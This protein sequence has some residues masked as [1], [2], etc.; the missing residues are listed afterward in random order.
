MTVCLGLL[1]AFV[2]ILGDY[3]TAARSVIF[4]DVPTSANLK[5]GAP[6]KVAGVPAGRVAVV[7]YR[8]GVYDESL[9]RR[10]FVRIHLEVDDDK[11]PTI[12]EDAMLYITTQGVLGEKY[13]EI[14]P[15][16]VKATP[17]QA[18]AI[19]TGEP[20]MRLEV[21]AHNANKLLSSL[22]RIVEENEDR[23]EEIL[24]DTSNLMKSAKSAAERID[25]V[26]AD[27]QDKI[28]VALDEFII[29]EK[30][31]SKLLSSAQTALGDGT[32]ARKTIREISKLATEVRGQVKPV[33][34]DLRGTLGR[35][36]TLADEGIDT[37]TKAKG[38]VLTLLDAGQM[39]V[40]EVTEILKATQK[41]DTTI[42]R[43]L[44]DTEIYDD[45]REMM[46]DLKRHPWKF[47]WKE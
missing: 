6:V 15:G 32:E 29:L 42:G 43:I 7:D 14:D 2:V 16:S 23:V 24:V 30:D 37:V 20:P 34:G 45:I 40:D 39:A 3:S 22:A 21:M 33:V 44:R 17:I 13:V 1:V 4:L 35:Y 26:L 8:G 18:G 12:R 28:G 36:R 38:K 5:P 47:I 41:A 27:N 10:V 31:A 11:I 9:D 19:L 46:R 25:K